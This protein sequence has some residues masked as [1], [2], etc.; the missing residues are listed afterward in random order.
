M[1]WL[2]RLWHRDRLDRELDRELRFHIDEEMRRLVA[3]GV[4]PL[5]A[6]R[7]ALAAFG[8][9]EPMPALTREARGVRWLDALGHDVRD[10]VRLMRRGP[11]FTATVLFSLTVGIGAN[12]AVFSVT[13]ALLLRPLPVS[14]PSAALSSV[15]HRPSRTSRRSKRY[16]SAP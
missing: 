15:G 7:Q 4:D 6:R 13:D 8:G 16:P 1:N 12:A 11:S 14:R 9:L 5:R 2:A 10:A 3:G